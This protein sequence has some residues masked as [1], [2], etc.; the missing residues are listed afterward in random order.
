MSTGDWTN[1]AGNQRAAAAR[2]A[3]PHSTAEIVAEVERAREAGLAVKPVGTGHSFTAAAVTDGVRLHLEIG[4]AS[5]RER[6]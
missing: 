2:V 1:W 5:C 3:L 4:R 6:V